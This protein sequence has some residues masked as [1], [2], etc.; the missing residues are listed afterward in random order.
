MSPHDR[1][2]ESRTELLETQLTQL[3]ELDLDTFENLVDAAC[4]I[5]DAESRFQQ[6]AG[7]GW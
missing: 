4:L 3:R 1:R 7:R 2:N 6:L 5:A